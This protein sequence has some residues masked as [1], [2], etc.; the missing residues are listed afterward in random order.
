MKIKR[1]TPIHIVEQIEPALPLWEGALGYQRVAEVPHDGKLGF[2]LLVNGDSQ[3]MFQ[4][5]A[6]AQADVPAMA[7]VSAALYV[8]VESLEEAKAAAKGLDVVL[9]ERTTFYGARELWVRDPA[10]VILG[11]AEHHRE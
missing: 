11:L 1:V 3:V 7:H 5:R 9:P 4:S 10:G 8:D 6:S 2:V